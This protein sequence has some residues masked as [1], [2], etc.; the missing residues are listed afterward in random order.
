MAAEDDDNL[1]GSPEV[2]VEVLSRSNTQAEMREKAALCL[3]T[4]SQEFWI[5]NPKRREITI[6]RRE[7]DTV[8]YNI[9]H[10]IPL[11]LLGGELN[12]ADIFS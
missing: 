1:Q 8:V 4:G 6:M 2:V 10:V 12:V 7:G 11:P 3:S 9:G 5:V